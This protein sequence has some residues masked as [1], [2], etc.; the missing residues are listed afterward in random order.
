MIELALSGI[1]VTSM[2]GLLIE[3]TKRKNLIAENTALKK[4]ITAV[5]QQT[6]REAEENEARLNK[7]IGQLQMA[8]F[9]RD[10]LIGELRMRLKAKDTI[11][12][13]KWESARG[14]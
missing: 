13:Q 11:I 6:R 4:H 2:I 7:T 3:R 12:R 8:V 14:E 10:E 9:H 5:K 1:A